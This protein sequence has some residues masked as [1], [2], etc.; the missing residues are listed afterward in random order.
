MSVSVDQ[1]GGFNADTL[2]VETDNVS[3]NLTLVGQSRD[4]SP[5]TASP[6]W[7]IKKITS[8]AKD[9]TRIEYAS[10]KFDQIWD[11]R[12][13]LF[14]VFRNT[15]SI[16]M[17]GVNDH[18]LLGDVAD[19][20]FDGTSPFSISVWFRS[21]FSGTQEKILFSKQA[22]VNNAGYRF[23]I[24]N[25]TLMFHLSGG[26]ANN[27]IEVESS[28]LIIHDN[29]WHSA[30]VTYDGSQNAGGVSI[31]F[32][33]SLQGAVANADSLTNSADNS[34]SAQYSGRNGTTAPFMG[35][36]DEL[37]AWNKELSTTEAD[38]IFDGGVPAN[39]VVHS[40][41]TN[42]RGWWRHD[43]DIFSTIIDQ[44]PNTSNNGTM[45]NMTATDLVGEVPE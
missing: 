27:R 43:G 34:I 35:F 23:A 31:Y 39:I 9:L 15:T 36:M 8:Q 11:D 7:L 3:N 45:I 21:T 17:D 33:G 12:D 22:N 5:S 24:E 29:D 2:A 10:Q 28:A 1:F 42:N 16:L 13:I 14:N 38:E 26:A 20:S 40:A 32:D 19:L 41:V 44:G 30:I 4:I 6:V 18:V 25:N 37:S